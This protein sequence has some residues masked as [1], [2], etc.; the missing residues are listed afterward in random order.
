M[1]ENGKEFL[2][3]SID[4]I[5]KRDEMDLLRTHKYVDTVSQFYVEFLRYANNDK[6][7]GLLTYWCD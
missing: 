7:L 6:G 4:D 2:E 3:D 1:I 5:D